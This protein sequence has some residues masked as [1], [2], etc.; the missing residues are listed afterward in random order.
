[1]SSYDLGKKGT[2]LEKIA[3][4]AISDEKL[5]RELLDEVKSKDNTKRFNAFN[6]LLIL[7]ENNPNFLYP[8]WDYFQEM[9]ESPNN[10]HKYIA[11]YILANLTA[12]DTDNRF[13]KI[14][15]DYFGLIE[16]DKTMIA[17]HVILNSSKIANNKL[18]MKSK[19]IEKLLKTDELH[20][21]RQKELIKS[22]AIE[23][24][25]KIKP[26]DKDK[27][28]IENFVKLQLESSSPKTR[29]AARCYIQRCELD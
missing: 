7:S 11:A 13:N 12:V 18:E 15:D 16:S 29:N 17:S 27:L 3:K 22:Y 4:E 28:E 10:Y 25:R 1:M 23:A 2:D 24:L 26:E 6:A 19:I 21:G 5:F 9:L 8:Y 20:R 14:F